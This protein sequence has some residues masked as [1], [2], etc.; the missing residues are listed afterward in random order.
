MADQKIF[1]FFYGL[2]TKTEPQI[3]YMFAKSME[4]DAE[5]SEKKKEQAFLEWK[6]ARREE[7]SAYQKEIHEQYI[8]NVEKDL[9]RLMTTRNSRQANNDANLQ[10]T[11]DKELEMHRLEHGPLMPTM[12]M[13]RRL[14]I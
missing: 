12:K 4:E 6:T 8:S 1:F 13:K 2:R 9:D 7:L 10:G 3:Y 14:K 11:M 5:L